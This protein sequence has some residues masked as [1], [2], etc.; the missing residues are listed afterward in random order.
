[1]SAQDP[2]HLSTTRTRPAAFTGLRTHAHAQVLDRDTGEPIRGPYA[3]G[4][5]IATMMGSPA[6]GGGIMLGP[7]MVF[8]QLAVCHLAGRDNASKATRTACPTHPRRA[9]RSSATRPPGFRKCA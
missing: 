8:G 5:D 1:M 6:V 3:A 9:G 7:A 2:A 4:N